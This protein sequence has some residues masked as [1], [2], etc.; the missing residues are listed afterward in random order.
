MSSTDITYKDNV[1]AS[2][3]YGQSWRELNRRM[4]GRAEE[5]KI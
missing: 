3:K 5:N 2:N 1:G 4:R